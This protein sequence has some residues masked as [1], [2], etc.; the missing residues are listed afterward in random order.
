MLVRHRS[1]SQPRETTLGVALFK[2]TW[3]KTGDKPRAEATTTTRTITITTTTA[4]SG[5]E[6]TTASDEIIM[7]MP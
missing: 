2:T 7:S 5:A 3:H 4:A 1:S 6:A